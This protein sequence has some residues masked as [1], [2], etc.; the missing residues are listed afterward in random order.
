MYLV[1]HLV[2]LYELFPGSI[3]CYVVLEQ[4]SLKQTINNFRQLFVDL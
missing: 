2:L 4:S 1:L 3:D